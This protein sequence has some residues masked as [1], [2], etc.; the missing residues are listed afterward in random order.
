MII[1]EIYNFFS[2]SCYV[3]C[4]KSVIFMNETIKNTVKIS[5]GIQYV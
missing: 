5:S 2:F 1:L 3:F 4:K